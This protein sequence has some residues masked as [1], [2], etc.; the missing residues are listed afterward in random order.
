MLTQVR[1]RVDP[2]AP[3]EEIP[4]PNN[5]KINSLPFLCAGSKNVFSF[6]AKH[7]V[8]V[9]M[10]Q[11][12]KAGC[13]EGANLGQGNHQFWCNGENQHDLNFQTCGAPIARSVAE[14]TKF[15]SM[16]RNQMISVSLNVFAKPRHCQG[17]SSLWWPGP[18]SAPAPPPSLALLQ[19]RRLSCENPL[20][21]MRL[22]R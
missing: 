4:T 1:I 2:G 15:A 18:S 9:W 12:N 17:C 11:P 3:G 13:R 20:G 21:P 7:K 10:A 14:M 16:T 19:T 5:P 8:S 22:P 6:F